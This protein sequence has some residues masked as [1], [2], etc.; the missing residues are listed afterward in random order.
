MRS[1][2]FYGKMLLILY[3]S[4]QLPKITESCVVHPNEAASHSNF[5][6]QHTSSPFVFWALLPCLISLLMYYFFQFICSSFHSSRRNVSSMRAGSLLYFFL[7]SLLHA[8]LEF[9]QSICRVAVSTLTTLRC[10][11]YP[12]LG[13]LPM[14]CRQSWDRRWRQPLTAA[15]CVASR[16]GLIMHREVFPACWTTSS[17]PYSRQQAKPRSNSEELPVFHHSWILLGK[18]WC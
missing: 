10:S 13:A 7:I 2:Q 9:W 16:P 15:G 6:L 4:G 8:I 1:H 12:L 18:K 3:V 14:K 17:I 5:T 11:G